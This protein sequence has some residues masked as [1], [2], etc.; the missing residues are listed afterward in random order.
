M[1]FSANWRKIRRREYGSIIGYCMR[2]TME[3][4][5]NRSERAHIKLWACFLVSIFCGFVFTSQTHAQ[6]FPR[7]NGLALAGVSQ[8][9]IYVEISTWDGL[10]L[11]PQEFRLNTQRLFEAGLTQAGASRRVAARDYL[12]C[13]VFATAAENEIAYTSRIEFWNMASVGVHH[14]LWEKG[15]IATINKNDFN[16]EAVA[17]LCVQY[18]TAEWNLH[19][20]R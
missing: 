1:Q 17:S 5:F 19:N 13:R 9:D 10:S 18:F 20:P 15:S 4:R 16:E 2:I 7:G 12:I 6:V 14:L 3:L 8:F 11:E